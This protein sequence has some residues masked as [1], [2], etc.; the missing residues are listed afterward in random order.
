MKRAYLVCLSHVLTAA[1]LLSQSNP[2]SSSNANIDWS[3]PVASPGISSATETSPA[4]AKAQAAILDRYGKLPLSFEANHGQTDPRV[5]FLSRTS[6]YT[7]FLT[8]DEAVFTLRGDQAAPGVLR[9][10]LHHAN[11][12]PS[13]I[14]VEEL[15]GKSNYFVGSDPANWRTNNPTYAEVKYEGVYPGIDLVYY[16]NQRQLE[17]DFIVAPGADP[18]QIAFDVTGSK[19]I[20]R[21]SHGDLVFQMGADEIRWRKPAVYQQKDGLRRQISA[22]YVISNTNRIAFELARYDARQPLYID[23]LIYSTFL[24]GS[25]T[26]SG[27]GIA[28]DSEGNAYVAGST[29]SANFPTMDPLQ[30]ARAGDNDAF[31]TKLNAAGTALIYSTFLGGSQNDYGKGIALDSSGNAYI[32]GYTNSANFPVTAAALQKVCGGTCSNNAFV[33][34]LNSSGS[35]LVYSTY[36]G[37]SG[38]AGD[39]GYGIAVGGKNGAYVA[40][41]TTS[42]DF[43]VTPGAFQTTYGGHGNAFISKLNSAGSALVYSTYLGGTKGDAGYAI[44]HDSNA[45]AYVTGGTHSPDFPTTPGAFQTVCN[46]PSPHG[47]ADAFVSE[48]NPAGSALI[49]STLIGGSGNAGGDGGNYGYGIAVD[50]SGSAYVTGYTG[51]NDFPL[52]NNFDPGYGSN[53]DGFVTRFNPAGSGLIFSTYLGGS[54]LDQG[55]GIT[56]DASG[57]AYIT[58]PTSSH[59][60]PVTAG[61]FQTICGNGGRH[62]CQNAFMTE[63]SASGALLYSTF[64]GGTGIDRGTIGDFGSAIAVDGS[65]NAYLT[66][67]SYSSDFSVTPAAFQTINAGSG[68]AFVAKI[69]PVAGPVATSTTLSSRPNPS[70]SGQPVTFTAVVNSVAGAPPNGETVS[71]M[72]GKVVL[73]TGT[74]SAGT[75]TF[76]TTAL[77]VGTTSVKAVYAGDSDFLGSAS[78]T[79]KQVVTKAEE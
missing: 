7:L 39:Y 41:Y 24:G 50:N 67:S 60:F 72:K 13:V 34:E 55:Q 8:V 62:P 65:G 38:A 61:A 22:R 16:G 71:F 6:K 48:L 76:T 49:Y 11:S 2:V 17:Y 35:A 54:N 1:F 30:P 27:N 53:G 36:L 33:A 70:T 19:R 45:N 78:N 63:L 5:K 32:V 59:D 28:V 42:S 58:G 64:L 69:Q 43:P 46:G 9:M 66:G 23:P 73:G 40:G 44:A 25:G 29:A 12:A 47:C 20:R 18:R 74:L 68:D 37:G 52:L 77:K 3:A 57:N 79:V 15:A 75:A 14:G 56:I 31:V 21:N 51:S 10:K 4:D 26:D